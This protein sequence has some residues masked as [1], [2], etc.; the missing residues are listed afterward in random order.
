MCQGL[1]FKRNQGLKSW[2]R[3]GSTP[4]R[5]RVIICWSSN[6]VNRCFGRPGGTVRP[7]GFSF[8]AGGTWELRRHCRWTHRSLRSVLACSSSAVKNSY[9]RQDRSAAHLKWPC[10]LRNKQFKEFFPRKMQ[11]ARNGPTESCENR[12]PSLNICAASFRMKRMLCIRHHS[13]DF[14]PH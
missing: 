12:K 14:P 13:L 8:V 3:T 2:S 7:A 6:N 1:S 5:R 9:Q 11:L 10:Q 4:I